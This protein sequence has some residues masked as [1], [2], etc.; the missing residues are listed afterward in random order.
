MNMI[1]AIQAEC[2]RVRKIIKIYDDLPG[3]VGAFGSTWM[4]ELIKQSEKAIA[5]A[6][7]VECV[8]CLKA[9]REVEA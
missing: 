5:H 3:G 1:E 8:A 7:A 2:D 9:L 6:D 4:N